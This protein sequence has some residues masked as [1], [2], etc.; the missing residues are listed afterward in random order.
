MSRSSAPAGQTLDLSGKNLDDA[1]L[2][3]LVDQ[4]AL[5]HQVGVLLLAGNRLTA[6][7]LAHLERSS[8]HS[9]HELDLSGNPIGDEGLAAIGRS[10]KCQ[11]LT[12]LKLN[13][14]GITREGLRRYLGGFT[15]R[16]ALSALWVNHNDLGDGSLEILL[17]NP[18]VQLMTL[19]ASH[20][21]LSDQG[22]RFLLEGP[23]Q[24]WLTRITLDGNPLSPQMKARLEVSQKLPVAEIILQP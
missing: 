17:G 22:A 18:N 21:K 8:V 23:A 1:G 15:S 19:G 24:E 6:G 5:H 3:A 10:P 4:G 9:L 2:A 11:Q 20:I 7:G 12:A 16:A 14:T 13:D